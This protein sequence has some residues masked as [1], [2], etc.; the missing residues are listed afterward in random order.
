MSA[1]ADA[2]EAVSRALRDS[3]EQLRFRSTRAA[4][5]VSA[6]IAELAKLRLEVEDERTGPAETAVRLRHAIERLNGVFA[7]LTRGS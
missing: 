6:V 2:A 7:R 4:S 3:H 1:K 5:E